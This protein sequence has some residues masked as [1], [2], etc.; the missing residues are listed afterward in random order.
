MEFALKEIIVREL[1]KLIIPNFQFK[2]ELCH[3]I[4][5]CDCDIFEVARNMRSDAH[6]VLFQLGTSL[7]CCDQY[8]N[9]IK[10]FFE[11]MSLKQQKYIMSNTLIVNLYTICPFMEINRIFK[12]YQNKLNVVL[13]E[14]FD[15]ENDRRNLFN[16]LIRDGN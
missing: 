16:I 13:R 6:R 10:P 15:N 4:F 5:N 1:N 3:R 2:K 7:M 12:T 14:N 8:M 11:E 9:L